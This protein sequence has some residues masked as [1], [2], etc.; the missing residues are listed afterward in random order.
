MKPI[1]SKEKLQTNS[2]MSITSL[3][4]THFLFVQCSRHKRKNTGGGREFA[5]EY[6]FIKDGSLKRL[7]SFLVLESTIHKV[8][9]LELVHL[10]G[11]YGNGPKETT[12]LF[13]LNKNP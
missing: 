12:V 13:Y 3:Y 6:F 2:C 9:E 10:G 4:T 5:Q 1:D 7:L 11:D 8:V